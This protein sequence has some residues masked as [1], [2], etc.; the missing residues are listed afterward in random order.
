M[1]DDAED[2]D[3][4]VSGLGRLSQAEEYLAQAEWTV[5]K[6]P[7]VSA[8]MTSRLHRNLGLLY[9]AKG[10]FPEALRHLADDVSSSSTLVYYTGFSCLSL[11]ILLC[12]GAMIAQLVVCWARCPA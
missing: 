12:A 6:T 4:F 1:C 11:T 2:D 9:A 8:A 3:N 10:D 5:L 7:N